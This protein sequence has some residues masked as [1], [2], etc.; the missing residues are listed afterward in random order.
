MSPVTKI[1]GITQT[2]DALLSAELG[3]R[4]LGYIFYPPSKRFIT[5][6]RAK[7]I[8]RHV[9]GAFPGVEHVGVFVNE[10]ASNVM[11]IRDEADLDFVQLHGEEN[12][13]YCQELTR[14]GLQIIKTLGISEQGCRSDFA[15]FATDFFLCDTYDA[16]LKGGTGKP[17]DLDK[18]PAGIPLGKTFIA[19]GINAENVQGLIGSVKCYG[20]DV[21]SGVE[22]APGIKSA[23]KLIELFRAINLSSRSTIEA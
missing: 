6:A 13:E 16:K 11:K 18:I 21:S 5:P 10:S 1:C 2:E 23:E 14:T 22:N 9:R 20:V 8:I 12:A 3:A 19:G 7:D 17:F 4:Y 15:D